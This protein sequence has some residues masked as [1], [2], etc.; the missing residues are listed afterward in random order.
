MQRTKLQCFDTDFSHR[1]VNGNLLLREEPG[2]EDEEE[3]DEHDDKG[4]DDG[5]AGYSE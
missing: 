1:S 2:E 5:D 3:D 4:D